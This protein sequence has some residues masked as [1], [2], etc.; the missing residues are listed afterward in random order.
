MFRNRIVIASAAF[1]L[2]GQLSIAADAKA[3]T[4]E[5]ILKSI[6]LPAD[7]EATV[8]AMPPDAGYPTSVSAS[9]DGVLFVAID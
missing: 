5:D 7:Y 4:G 6:K 2:A 1:A 3:R 9:P 8:F